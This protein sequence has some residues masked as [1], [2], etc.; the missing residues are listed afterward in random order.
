MCS[1]SAMGW[2]CLLPVL[3][4]CRNHRPLGT[5][6]PPFGSISPKAIPAGLGVYFGVPRRWMIG[7]VGVIVLSVGKCRGD[8]AANLLREV[9]L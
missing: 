3:M 4:T 9:E 1:V 7:V 6:G 2:R 8:A 5:T